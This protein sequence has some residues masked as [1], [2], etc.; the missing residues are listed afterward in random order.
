MLQFI[1]KNPE[2]LNA[3]TD[4]NATQEQKNAKFAELMLNNS[5]FVPMMLELFFGNGSTENPSSP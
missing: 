3:I 5:E 4:P 2:F 1:F